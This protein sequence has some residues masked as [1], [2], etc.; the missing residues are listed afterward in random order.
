MFVSHHGSPSSLSDTLTPSHPFTHQINIIFSPSDQNLQ[1]KL[2]KV[3]SDYQS[4][5][6]ELSEILD[7]SHHDLIGRFDYAQNEFI[8]LAEGHRGVEDVWCIDHRGLLT[9]LLTKDTYQQLGLVGERASK[10]SEIYYVQV[11]LHDRTSSVYTRAKERI[12][13]WDERRK[14][15]GVL[16]WRVHIHGSLPSLQAKLRSV[17]VQAQVRTLDDILIPVLDEKKN[18]F[19][20]TRN[21]RD[22]HEGHTDRDEEN[23]RIEELFEWVG[24]A[25]MESE[26]LKAND[27]PNLFVAQY[28]APEPSRIGSVTHVQWSGFLPP[29]FVRQV[30]D[31]AI[32]SIKPGSGNLEA[33]STSPSFISI[34]ANLHRNMPISYVS[35]KAFREG[36][37][38]EVRM[39][40]WERKVDCWSLILKNLVSGSGGGGDDGAG[41]E[42]DQCEWVLAYVES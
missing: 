30:L 14:A 41:G 42:G 18:E 34:T 2:Q 13:L 12:R 9:L 6:A 23:E 17:K 29:S 28:E 31:T 40:R 38:T 10:K 4:G 36:A 35:P 24:M 8:A 27:R 1:Q 33:A 19:A 21:N 7:A 25:C 16:P 20:L 15:Q 26:R 32:G 11:D 5:R 3:E 37:K 39:G 22:G